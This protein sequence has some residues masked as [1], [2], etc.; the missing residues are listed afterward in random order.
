M[1][2][3]AI[4][5]LM[6]FSVVCFYGCS[7]DG[8]DETPDSGTD[9]G[10]DSGTEDGGTDMGTGDT[11][12]SFDDVTLRLLSVTIIRPDGVGAILEPLIN[13]DIEADALHV[14]IQ[15]S[16]FAGA[17]PTEFSITGNAGQAVEGGYTWYEG[18]AIDSAAATIDADGNFSGG[19]LS[20][21]FPALEP[22]ATEPLQIPVSN[23]QLDGTLFEADGVWAIEGTL[24][25][26][27]LASEI[28]GIDVT[29]VPGNDGVPLS[30]LLDPDN[31]DYP[32]DSTE[33]TGWRL[34]AE[35]LAEEATFVAAE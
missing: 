6:V 3:L 34:E 21:I 35:I 23:L 2:R 1:L 27:I 32:V 9:T 13:N 22:G 15:M 10:A 4:T 33:P 7:D 26:A 20:I 31:M 29:L 19:P 25:G 30:Q 28:E 18:V 16:G 17:W 8:G 5:L 14:L 11:A 12:G 24:A